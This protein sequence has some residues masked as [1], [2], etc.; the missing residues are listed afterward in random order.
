MDAYHYRS[1][2]GVKEVTP[3]MDR[4]LQDCNKYMWCV[5]IEVLDSVVMTMRSESKLRSFFMLLPL[6]L[7]KI[8]NSSITTLE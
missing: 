6:V 3:T 1:K 8:W 4:A 2:R 7:D 5:L